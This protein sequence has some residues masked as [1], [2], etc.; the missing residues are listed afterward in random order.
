MAM[1]TAEAVIVLIG[2]VAAT[3][4]KVRMMLR[5]LAFR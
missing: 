1:A 2:L 3:A 4:L 5:A